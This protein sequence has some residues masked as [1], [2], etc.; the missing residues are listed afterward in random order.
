MISARAFK[1]RSFVCTPLL[2][3]TFTRT[4]PFLPP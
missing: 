3:Q 2:H 1:R 4:T